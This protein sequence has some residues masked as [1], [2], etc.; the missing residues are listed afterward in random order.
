MFSEITL[1]ET[2]RTGSKAS[3]DQLCGKLWLYAFCSASRMHFG[4]NV[5]VLHLLRLNLCG[6]YGIYYC[7][8]MSFR[9]VESI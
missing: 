5:Y 9:L 3:C 6:R 4:Q 7:A 8:L 1:D 2:E